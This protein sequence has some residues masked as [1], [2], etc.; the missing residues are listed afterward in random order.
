MAAGALASVSLGSRRRYLPRLSRGP[1]DPWIKRTKWKNRFGH[2]SRMRNSC[3]NFQIPWAVH[4]A[5]IR[6]RVN[7]GPAQSS[8][9]EKFRN[10]PRR[11]TEGCGAI[12]IFLPAKARLKGYSGGALLLPLL[13]SLTSYTGENVRANR[14]PARTRIGHAQMPAL[15]RP[16]RP[17]LLRISINSWLFLRA[18]LH[19]KSSLPRRLWQHCTLCT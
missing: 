13:L 5:N 10:W 6:I 8:T 2:P 18:K 15:A 17:V 3:V 11:A 19:R 9:T 1:G 7:R 4:S 14:P 16:E 12:D